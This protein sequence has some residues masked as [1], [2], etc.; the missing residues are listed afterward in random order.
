MRFSVPFATGGDYAPHTRE[1]GGRAPVGESRAH[2]ALP[3]VFS[4][5]HAGRNTRSVVLGEGGV[6]RRISDEAPVA[7]EAKTIAH[8]RRR[9]GARLDEK[10]VRSAGR[11]VNANPNASPG[12]GASGALNVLAPPAPLEP[13]KASKYERYASSHAVR[14]CM[15]PT[16]ERGQRRRDR[17]RSD[18]HR[19]DQRRDSKGSRSSELGDAHGHD[20]DAHRRRRENL[21]LAGFGGRHAGKTN[22]STVFQDG[23]E[24]RRRRPH[25]GKANRSTLNLAGGSTPP[26]VSYR[27]EEER[28]GARRVLA[29]SNVFKGTPRAG[30]R[31]GDNELG[32]GRRNRGLFAEEKK[33][34]GTQADGAQTLLYSCEPDTQSAHRR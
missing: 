25:A 11:P 20:G 9:K 22:C 17:E 30:S 12:A 31:A 26:P 33:K 16:T 18:R 2:F 23:E 5:K 13:R 29:E 21:R 34:K 8:S 27:T 24:R 28:R 3:K 10:A 15:D 6:P 4:G 7:G 1:P 32:F 14:E 19:S